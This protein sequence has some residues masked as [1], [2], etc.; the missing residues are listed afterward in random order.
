MRKLSIWT[1]FLIIFICDNILFAQDE[2]FNLVKF[3]IK[4]FC[5]ITDSSHLNSLTNK[6]LEKAIEESNIELTGDQ[7]SLPVHV[8]YGFQPFVIYR[9]YSFLQIG[10]KMDF[11]FSNFT[12]EFENPLNSQKYELNINMR[13]HNPGIFAYYTFDEL[14]LGG[15]IFRA[16][17]NLHVNDNFFG[18]QDIWYGKGTGYELGLGFSTT[19]EKSIGFTMS[20]KYRILHIDEFK[21]TL[22]RTVIR[23]DTQE[24]M[25]LNMSG[26]VIDLGFYF[27]FVKSMEQEN[28]E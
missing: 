21:D 15:G 4:G 26:L 22:N 25:S 7:P 28:E 13:S 9:P 23:S 24:N 17:T 10:I 14:E 2:P 1:L 27:Q 19:A 20:L 12:A 16:Y 8:E 5:V 18:Y 6:W 11:G 3:G